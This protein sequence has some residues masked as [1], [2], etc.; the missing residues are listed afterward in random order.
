MV[1]D[2]ISLNTGRSIVA[3]RPEEKQ[4]TQTNLM[5]VDSVVTWSWVG[6]LGPLGDEELAAGLLHPLLLHL[7]L[8]PLWPLEYVSKQIYQRS[9]V[10]HPVPRLDLGQEGQEGQ[11]EARA[12]EHCEEWSLKKMK[13]SCLSLKLTGKG[14]STFSLSHIPVLSKSQ[15]TGPTTCPSLIVRIMLNYKGSVRII[16]MTEPQNCCDGVNFLDVS[17]YDLFKFS[18]VR[19]S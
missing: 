9:G 19:L 5:T 11:H 15:L 16:I 4:D 3:A 8:H 13:S 1:Q 17:E 6:P 2:S 14:N 10:L 18:L 7:G 12:D